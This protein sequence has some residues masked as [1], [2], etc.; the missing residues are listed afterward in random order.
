MESMSPS[1]EAAKLSGAVAA[2]RERIEAATEAGELAAVAPEDVTNLLTAGIKLYAAYAE[3]LETEVPP[4]DSS[5]STT[6]AM[7]VA[8]ALLRAQ[9]MNPFDLA[10]WFQKTTPKAL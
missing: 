9:H 2:V 8:C 7:V 4:V 10:V 1:E 3:E 5:L 6:E